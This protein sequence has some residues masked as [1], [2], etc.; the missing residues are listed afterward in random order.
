MAD[1]PRALENLM[2]SNPENRNKTR[3][4]HES[5]VT[6]ENNQ[7]GVLRG[8]RMYNYSDFGVYFEADYRLEPE[9][10]LR[11]GITN[12]PFAS[13]PDKYESYRGIIKWRKL[14]KRSA[15]Y[16]GYGMQ[17]LEE[18]TRN[19]DQSQFHGSREHSRIECAIPIKYEYDSRTYEGTA[20]DVS[21]GGVFIKTPDLVAVGQPVTVYIAVK[22]KVKIKKLNGRVT[23]SNRTGFG[24]K[25]GRSD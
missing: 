7:I 6:L 17:L 5:P 2:I 22:K 8:A 20:V 1:Q 18:N 12:S 13:E 24:V 23:W 14:L 9:T 3:F 10:E 19:E 11:I 25:F 21:S 15:H 16:Y 4:D